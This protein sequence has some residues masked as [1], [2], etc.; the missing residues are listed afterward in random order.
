MQHC[1]AVGYMQSI[2]EQS[3]TLWEKEKMLVVFA[4]S[5]IIIL[6]TSILSSANASNLD[7]AKILPFGE[8][9]KAN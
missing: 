7:V 5:R 2:T 3:K 9:L 4:L 8:V 6:T 1:V